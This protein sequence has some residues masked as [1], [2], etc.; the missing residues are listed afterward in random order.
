MLPISNAHES[1]HIENRQNFLL[2][3]TLM[4]CSEQVKYQLM[5]HD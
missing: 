3:S 5:Q 1:F 2:I 4:T